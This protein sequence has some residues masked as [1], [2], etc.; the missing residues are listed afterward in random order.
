MSTPTLTWP[1]LAVGDTVRNCKLLRDTMDTV[2]EVSKLIKLSPKQNVQFEELNSNIHPETPGFRVLL[3][4]T[5]LT[6][7]ADCSKNVLN[8]YSVI[9]TFWDIRN[10]DGY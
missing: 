10:G 7:R 1:L 6:V 8:N 2:H 9:Q 4:P 3:C 5:R